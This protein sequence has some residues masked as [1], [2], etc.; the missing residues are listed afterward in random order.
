[1]SE[2]LCFFTSRLQFTSKI[3]GSYFCCH[4]PIKNNRTSLSSSF[5]FSRH[6]EQVNRPNVGARGEGERGCSRKPSGLQILHQDK[7]FVWEESEPVALSVR[8]R[9]EPLEVHE[10][11]RDA[12]AGAHWPLLP[13]LVLGQQAHLTLPRYE[14]QQRR[15]HRLGLPQSPADRKRL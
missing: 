10:L 15:E 7:T 13:N 3:T 14:K 1:M 9:V 6:L 12:G 4:C 5:C 8:K 2:T 11:Q